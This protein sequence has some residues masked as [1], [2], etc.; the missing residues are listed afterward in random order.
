V[1]CNYN[2]VEEKRI[3][4]DM[5]NDNSSLSETDRPKFKYF[6]LMKLVKICVYINVFVALIELDFGFSHLL[7]SIS[8]DKI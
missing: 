6:K 1:K 3:G 8:S 2:R 4:G 5:S 7:I